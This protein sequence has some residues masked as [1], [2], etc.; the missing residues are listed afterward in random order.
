MIPLSESLKMLLQHGML[1]RSQK[2]SDVLRNLAIQVTT[3]GNQ[4]WSVWFCLVFCFCFFSGWF[5]WLQDKGWKVT[6]LRG[7]TAYHPGP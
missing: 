7:V 3:K 6:G 2:V 5:P 1:G 4:P